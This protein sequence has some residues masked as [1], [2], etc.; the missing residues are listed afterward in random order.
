MYNAG[1]ERTLRHDGAV[2]NGCLWDYF[3]MS[4][5]RS[6]I[7]EWQPAPLPEPWFVADDA[8]RTALAAELEKELTAGHPLFGEKIIPIAKCG[9]CDEAVFSI[10]G[11]EFVQW[12]R[13][14]MT[15]SRKSE[16]S[17]FPMT[18]LFNSLR[19]AVETHSH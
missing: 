3:L 10:E 4:E 1:P 17:P 9:G 7:S 11:E 5:D 6:T 15:W 13:V 19:S 12:A 18:T 14:H 8:L 16:S 2:A